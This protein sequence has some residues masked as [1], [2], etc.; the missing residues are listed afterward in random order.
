MS[1]LPPPRRLVAAHATDGTPVLLEHHFPSADTDPATLKAQV[2]FLQPDLVAKPEK[3]VEWAEARPDK[4]SHDDAISARY[5]DLPPSADGFFHFTQTIDYL[6]ITHGE[7]EMELHDGT[8]TTVHPGDLVVQAANIHRWNNLKPE[9]A[10][11]IAFVGPSEA[12]KVDGKGL[13]EPPFNGY[14]AKF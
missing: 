8:K 3:A 2:L 1:S 10:R 5:I 4:I 9:W 7:L 12:V 6:V 13:E 14:L 11:F